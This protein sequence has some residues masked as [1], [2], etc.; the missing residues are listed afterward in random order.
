M[1]SE[2]KW[3][4]WWLGSWFVP[5]SCFNLSAHIVQLHLY[6]L[7]VGCT[8]GAILQQ[9]LKPI[10]TFFHIEVSYINDSLYLKNN[11]YR[12]KSKTFHSKNNNADPEV[13]MLLQSLTQIKG[14]K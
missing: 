2:G 5:V 11:L 3:T 14:A 4:G 9:L 10:N 12:G 1:S 6:T 7:Y 13:S 8:E